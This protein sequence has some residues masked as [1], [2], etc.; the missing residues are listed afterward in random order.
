MARVCVLIL[1]RLGFAV[2]LVAQESLVHLS[3]DRGF[4]RRQASGAGGLNHSA[5]LAAH[6]YGLIGE[7]I[8]AGKGNRL[9]IRNRISIPMILSP[10]IAQRKRDINAL[11]LNA[12]GNI[13]LH[14]ST[15]KLTVP[16]YTQ[17]LCACQAECYFRRFF[18]KTSH[19]SAF[20]LVFAAIRLTAWRRFPAYRGQSAAPRWSGCAAP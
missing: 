17:F 9:D 11:S 20:S 6:K 7:H 18:P 1:V 5:G 4:R 10:D 13:Q 15:S 8:C 19:S 16:Y 14:R 12:L 3:G 2:A